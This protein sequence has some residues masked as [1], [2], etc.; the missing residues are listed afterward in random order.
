MFLAG[1]SRRRIFTIV[2]IVVLAIVAYVLIRH[3]VPKEVL[4][5]VTLSGGSSTS[6]QDDPRVRFI[7]AGLSNVW[8][9]PLLGVGIGAFGQAVLGEAGSS[10]H[11][12]WLAALVELGCVGLT[13]YA[14]YNLMLFRLALRMPRREKVLYLGLLLISFINSNTVGSLHDKVTWFLQVMVMVQAAACA[15]LRST[16]KPRPFPQQAARAFRGQAPHLPKP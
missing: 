5:R 4:S 2:Q 13:I 8:R 9:N 3:A 12:A 10:A 15:K 16:R 6:I 7:K 1:L 11:N 14:I